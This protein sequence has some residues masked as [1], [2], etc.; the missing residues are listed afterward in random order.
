VPGGSTAVAQGGP[1][2]P[3]ERSATG[4]GERRLPRQRVHA[5]AEDADLVAY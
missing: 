5:R 3:A 1:D 2:A 4:T